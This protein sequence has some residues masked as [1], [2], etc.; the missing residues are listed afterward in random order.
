[1]SRE[2][3]RL[4]TA[5]FKSLRIVSINNHMKLSQLFE[6]ISN[7]SV[8]IKDKYNL[9]SFYAYENNDMITLDMLE[10]PKTERKQGIGTAVMTELVNYADQNNKR[11]VLTPGQQEDDRGTTSRSRLVKF[12]KRFGFI[13]NKGRKKDFT[14][15]QGMYRLPK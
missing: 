3:L 12:Y 7:F 10:V 8:Y 6:N 11:I 13:E 5:L 4:I 15:S 1:M 2:I 14:I 9:S